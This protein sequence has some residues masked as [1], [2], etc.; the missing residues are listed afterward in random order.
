MRAARPPRVIRPFIRGDEESGE[1][2]TPIA[3]AWIAEF[4]QALRPYVNGAY[5]NVP[6]I[7]MQDWA[8]AYWDSNFDRL[9]K[10]KTKYDPC[11]I[12][13]YEQSIPSASW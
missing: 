1:P 2:L 5:V 6:N 3:Q 9:R 7:G 10:I 11:N 8:T 13:Q 12:F 4:S